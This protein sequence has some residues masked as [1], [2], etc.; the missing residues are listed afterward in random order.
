MFKK[1]F[2]KFLKKNDDD[3]IAKISYVMKKGEDSPIVDIVIEDYSGE[4]LNGLV[5]ILQTVHSDN[6]L[7]ETVNIIVDS[8]KSQGKEE[9]IVE[10]CMKLGNNFWNTTAEVLQKKEESKKTNDKEE[11]PCIKPSDMLQ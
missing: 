1:I 4:S 11:G 6:C 5:K 3:H 9:E 7:V 8:L 2:S 10:L